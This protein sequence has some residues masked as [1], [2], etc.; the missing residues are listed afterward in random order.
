V[1]TLPVLY[2]QRSLDPSDSRLLE[3]LAGDL[4]DETRHAEALGLLRVHPAIQA[5][6]LELEQW[7]ADARTALQPLPAI[8]AK[9]ALESLCDFVVSRTR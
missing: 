6:Q 8:P 9:A 1:A 2:A 5:A 3:L 7:A 4:T